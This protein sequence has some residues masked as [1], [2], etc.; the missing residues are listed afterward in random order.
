MKIY[1]S[2]IQGL[3]KAVRDYLA[4][5]TW[6]T[7]DQ[8]TAAVG[9]LIP[10]A[11]AHRRYT[12]TRR[13]E[14]ARQG[15]RLDRPL[16]KPDEQRIWQGRRL[17]VHQ[18]IQYLK[19]TGELEVR[20]QRGCYEIRVRDPHP[21]VAANAPRLNG[22]LCQSI[23]E[24]LAQGD[25]RTAAELTDAVAQH[26][27]PQRA[28]A[29]YAGYS[30]R[31]RQRL[32]APKTPRPHDLA[33]CIQLGRRLLVRYA[34]N[35][36]RRDGNVVAQGPAHARQYRWAYA[37]APNA[38]DGLQGKRRPRTPARELSG[39]VARLPE[40]DSM[41]S[42]LQPGDSIEV[43]CAELVWVGL[44]EVRGEA[45]IV[46][47]VVDETAQRVNMALDGSTAQALIQMVSEE[48]EKGEETS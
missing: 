2:K 35:S 33:T 1:S 34:L 21:Q 9:S 37:P 3:S 8:V 11:R 15:G 22:L 28:E 31:L 32:G 18:T 16:T 12:Q 23:R 41:V 48:L 14:R 24:L 25:A 30:A 13:S 43:C 26:I 27:P 29:V 47:G 46:L 40:E 19:K 7:I 38:S 44:V 10:A 45:R 6:H 20:G 4:D 42:H 5:G 39:G 36:M 17:R